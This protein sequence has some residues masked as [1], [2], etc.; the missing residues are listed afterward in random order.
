MDDE[1][2]LTISHLLPSSSFFGGFL[3]RMLSGFGFLPG[4]GLLARPRLDVLSLRVG[5]VA[6][7]RNEGFLCVISSLLTF[8]R[9]L[10]TASPL[11]SSLKTASMPLGFAVAAGSCWISNIGGGP[12][13]GGGGGGALP[14]GGV[15]VVEVNAT[16][17]AST[18][19]AASVGFIPLGFQ[20]KPFGNVSLAYSARLLNMA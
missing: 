8:L 3:V 9:P 6:P 5:T 17:L 15:G 2:L 11:L 4:M 14:V 16:A 18:D 20:S 10:V 19:I 1:A 13:G 12:G 7:A